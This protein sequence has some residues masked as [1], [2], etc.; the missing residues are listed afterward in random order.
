MR[1]SSLRL[2][3]IPYRAPTARELLHAL[4]DCVDLQGETADGRVVLRCAVSA[5]LLDDLAAWEADAPEDDEVDDGASERR[6]YGSG[7]AS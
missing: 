1:P 7:S 2:F 5:S 4:L 6:F 3:D